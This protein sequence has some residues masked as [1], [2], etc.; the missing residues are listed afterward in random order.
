MQK[1]SNAER[2]ADGP[3]LLEDTERPLE[4]RRLQREHEVV[5]NRLRRLR[6]VEQLLLGRAP[7]HTFGQPL[8]VNEERVQPERAARRVRARVARRRRQQRQHHQH[9]LL[10]ALHPREERVERRE[11]SNPGVS[12]GA[13]GEERL[14][15]SRESAEREHV[16]RL[17]TTAAV[18][19]T[20]Q[21]GV[22]G[23]RS[24][25]GEFDMI[26]RQVAVIG[27]LAVTLITGCNDNTVLEVRKDGTG[28]G[29][30]TSRLLTM[31]GPVGKGELDCGEKCTL[32]TYF[33]NTYLL[34]ATPAPGSRFVRWD[35]DQCP[36]ELVRDSLDCEVYTAVPG[37]TVVTATFNENRLTVTKA[38]AG[39]GRV[40][41]A[42]TGIDCGTSCS[43]TF[44]TGTSVTL[45]ATAETGS[46]FTGWSGAC[47]GSSS[48]CVITALDAQNVTATFVKRPGTLTVTKAGSGSGSVISMPSGIDCGTTCSAMYETGSAVSLTPMPASGSAFAGWSGACAGMSACSVTVQEVTNVTATFT[49]VSLPLSVRFSGVGSGRV[50][51][52]PAG[53]DCTAD[54]MSTFSTGTMVTL[55][56]VAGTGSA[57]TGWGGACMGTGTCTV[58]LAAATEVI[59][60]FTPAPIPLTVVRAG[61]GSGTVISM[62]TGIDCGTT[63]TASFTAATTVTLIAT[64]DATSIFTGWSGACSGMTTCTVPLMV[65]STVTAT[66]QLRQVSV[67]VMLLG[68]GTGVVTS[69]PHGHRLRRDV[70]GQLPRGLDGDVDA[71][72]DGGL[73]VH[74]VDGRV[75]GQRRVCG[76]ADDGRRSRRD[77]HARHVSPLGREGRHGR[78]HGLVEPRWRLVRRDLHDVVGLGQRGDARGDA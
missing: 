53:V 74:G 43:A 62:P 75:H 64:A 6:L 24:F 8:E 13:E 2:R 5:P 73:H 26:R 77:V 9:A 66:F 11:V 72:G 35:Y 48:T 76:D 14:Q 15:N 21:L 46:T 12:V 50:T 22:R 63:C 44:D 41:S 54:C 19:R 55:T 70:L 7:R 20:T 56:A 68:T 23:A 28:K 58:T 42:P 49:T 38:G 34:T 37:P 57:F 4:R 10:G 51:S 39:S 78:R 1:R 40:V 31:P 36:P 30:V 33:K 65:A 52:L 61:S 47:S 45:T 17:P 18:R 59:A 71:D 60:T 27:L 67:S 3:R 25:S 29:T 69:A 32:D 16:E